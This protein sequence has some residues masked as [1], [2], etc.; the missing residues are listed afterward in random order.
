MG[1]G[2]R[3]ATSLRARAGGLQAVMRDAGWKTM[4]AIPLSIDLNKTRNAGGLG[5]LLEGRVSPP[6]AKEIP[7]AA[8][9]PGSRRV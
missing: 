3:G 9:T 6:D 2:R 4:K 8:H 1:L 7:S 5:R